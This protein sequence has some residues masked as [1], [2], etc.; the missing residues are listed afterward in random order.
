M[1]D[2]LGQ[3][4]DVSVDA[5][6]AENMERVGSQ[7]TSLSLQHLRILYIYDIYI[8]YTVYYTVYNNCMFIKL[9]K[10]VVG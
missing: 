5:A 10:Y 4:G 3:V 1:S 8:Y 9:Y 7:N 2:A 6:S